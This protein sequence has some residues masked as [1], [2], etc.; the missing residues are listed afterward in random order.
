MC[1]FAFPW[2]GLNN[3]IRKVASSIISLL[4]IIK[5]HAQGY[6]PCISPPPF[7]GLK[8]CEG[9]GGGG[10]GLILG[11]LRYACHLFLSQSFFIREVLPSMFPFQSITE[12][13]FHNETEST[14]SIPVSKLCSQRDGTTSIPAWKSLGQADG[15]TIILGRSFSPIERT[16]VEIM[17]I[18]LTG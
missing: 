12:S 8:L 14:S 10:G 15:T 13:K 3:N 9:G 6:I 1:V 4:W 2:V 7:L 11:S 16:V 5:F 17:S 18:R